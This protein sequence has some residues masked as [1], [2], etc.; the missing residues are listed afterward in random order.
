MRSQEY[1]DPFG[2]IPDFG[3][4]KRPLAGRA[5]MAGDVFSPQMP[6]DLLNRFGE[7][8]PVKLD[9]RDLVIPPPGPGLKRNPNYNPT[10]LPGIIDREILRPGAF[11][12][13]GFGVS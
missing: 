1:G 8:A 6:L 5:R 10:H 12:A 11:G 13:G 3:Q 2:A 9:T 7:S 4:G